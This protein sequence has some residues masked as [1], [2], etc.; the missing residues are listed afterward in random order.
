MSDL[1]ID[2]IGPTGLKVN[3]MTNNC[4][5]KYHYFYGYSRL[6]E[7]AFDMDAED[8]IDNNLCDFYNYNYN[9]FGYGLEKVPLGDLNEFNGL[10]TDGEWTLVISDTVSNFDGTLFSFGIFVDPVDDDVNFVPDFCQFNNFEIDD[11]NFGDDDNCSYNG[12]SKWSAWGTRAMPKEEFEL[13]LIA[14]DSP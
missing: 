6:F 2:L 11:D 4:E 3:L 1:V 5:L 9:Y 14:Y 8:D 7:V 13:K 12:A 10:Q